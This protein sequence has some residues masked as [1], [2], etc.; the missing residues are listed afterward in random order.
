MTGNHIVA[1]EFS[2]LEKRHANCALMNLLQHLHDGVCLFDGRQRLIAC[3]DRY[4]EIYKIPIELTK[5][6]VSLIEILKQRIVVNCIPNVEG[7]AYIADRLQTAYDAVE[8]TDVHHMRDGR[9]LSVRHKPLDGGGWL[10]THTDITE[11]YDLK[12]EI[13]HMA[14]HDL[15]TDLC[16]RRRIED[17]VEAAVREIK[18][19]SCL[20]L[21]FLDLDNFKEINDQHGHAAGDAVLKVIAERL[22]RCFR[23]RDVVSRLGG[24]EFAILQTGIT[25][26]GSL[27]AIARRVVDLISKPISISGKK[28]SVGASIGIIYSDD[29]ATDVSDLWLQADSVMY[30]AKNG[31]GGNFIARQYCPDIRIAC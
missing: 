30:D 16:N 17:C 5:T 11:I 22:M 4:A 1:V 10:S 7:E 12:K 25:E 3:N 18:R 29:P 31:G 14:Y 21:M 2:P 15:L 28:M 8:K 27:A 23:G 26:P 6:G 13:E 20:A 9:V 24:D 19:G